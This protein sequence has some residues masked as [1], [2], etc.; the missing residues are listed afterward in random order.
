[1]CGVLFGLL[2]RLLCT[3]TPGQNRSVRVGTDEPCGSPNNDW[4]RL[5]LYHTN[6]VQLSDI[7]RRKE[8]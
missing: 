3:G 8:E 2:Y 6:E 7:L 5:Y 4:G 1:M